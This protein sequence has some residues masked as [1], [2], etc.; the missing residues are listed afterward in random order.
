MGYGAFLSS[1][2]GRVKSGG[3]GQRSMGGF[4]AASLVRR[5]MDLLPF[6]LHSCYDQQLPCLYET[7]VLSRSCCCSLPV[8]CRSGSLDAMSR[9]MFVSKQR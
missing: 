2:V 7:R 3:Y 5:I 1:M 8:S 4:F 9:K 6:T